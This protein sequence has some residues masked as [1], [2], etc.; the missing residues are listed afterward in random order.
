MKAQIILLVAA[1]IFATSCERN[2]E[3]SQLGTQVRQKETAPAVSAQSVQAT[4]PALEPPEGWREGVHY[5]SIMPPL[6]TSTGPGKI[7]VIEFFWHSC[8]HC[9]DLEPVLEYWEHRAPEDVVLIRVP[10]T[11]QKDSERT[12]ARL[13]YTLQRLG[14]LDLHRPFFDAVE[15][16][17]RAEKKNK[18]DTFEDQKSFALGH[19]IEAQAFET[20]YR[21]DAVSADVVKADRM[22]LDYGI[23]ATPSIV[24]QGKYRTT[25]GKAGGLSQSLVLTDELIARERN[26]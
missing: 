24:V 22:A 1:A 2:S 3:L 17:K 11:W 19:G 7:E 23:H 21:S 13:Y 26:H 18:L 9:R 25:T 5:E 12:Y 8:P 15:A 4:S 20:L 6:P 16:G 14:R 10:V